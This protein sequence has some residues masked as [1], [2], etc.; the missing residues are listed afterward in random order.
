VVLVICWFAALFLG[1][2]PDGLAGFLAG[3]LRWSTR[4]Y[5]YLFLLTDKYPPFELA[6]AD[7]PVRLLVR[8]GRLNRLAVLFRLIL[9]IPAWI[10]GALLV[11]GMWTITMFVTWLIVLIAGRMPQPLHEAIA[12]GMRF[13]TRLTA[14]VFLLT[15]SYPW[16]LFGD[17][18]AFPGTGQAGYLPTVPGYPA[19]AG[20][21][22]PGYGQPGY[23]Q[24][25][26][27]QPAY[28]QP[29]YGPLPGQ[30]V[31]GLPGYGQPVPGQPGYGQPVPGQPGYGQAVPGQPAPGQPGYGQPGYGP[32][33]FS[34]EGY[35]QPGYAA[36]GYGQPAAVTRWLGGDQP[37]RLVLSSS[38]KALVGMFLALG[39]L[40]AVVY[41]V[42][43]AVGATSNNSLSRAAAAV[44]VESSYSTLDKSLVTFSSKTAACQG[45]LSCVTGL[46]QQ[47][48]QAFTTFGQD[49]RNISMPSPAAVTAAARVASDSTQAANDF[50]RLSRVTSVSQYQQVVVSTGLQSLLHQF[51]ADY[52]SLG[53]TLGMG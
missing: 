46:D 49:I 25:G 43:I 36:A 39:V 44:S 29:G 26:Y 47:M 4:V 27:G 53:Q 5:A 45:K 18:P 16:G 23:G 1:R 6:D 21:G 14:Y 19:A 42:V 28:G 40:L 37:W 50:Q 2:L 30:P 33:G 38:A 11:Y 13:Q 9:V 12:A 52:Q 34:Q 20:Y 35:G 10:I 3:Y 8:P 31:P 51:D 32:P 41:V 17:E 24:P 22:Q 48:S 15:G 7:Y